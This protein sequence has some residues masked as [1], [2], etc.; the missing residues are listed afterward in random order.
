M[1]VLVAKKRGFCFGVENAMHLA[2]NLLNQKKH[3][4]CLG[5]LIH[6]RQAVARL[7]QAGLKV[8]DDIHEIPSFEADGSIPTVLI[9]SHGCGPAIIEELNKRGLTVVDA[10]CV[11]VK[12]LQKLA[13]QCAHEGF[14]VVVVGDKDH[15]EIQAVI[16]YVPD[17]IVIGG[18]DDLG[19]LPDAGRLAV[20]SQTT[21]SGDDFGKI[22]GLIAGKGYPEIRVLNT[23][24]RETARRQASAIELCH[25]VDVMFV[26]GGKHSANTG[27]L[28]DLCRRCG[29][30][31]YHL[32]G[33]SEFK[34]QYVAGKNVAGVTA[35]ASTPE[36]IIQ[37]FVEELQKIDGTSA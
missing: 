37:N 14:Q 18:E 5:E 12:K 32:Q 34:P 21:Y 8:V 33:W 24:C 31:T 29:V 11:L 7:T 4:Y 15:P 9:R 36:W 10:T 20:M 16:G 1:K 13:Q 30:E 35:G 22:V 3:V 28:A 2:E 25:A 27:E 26:L 6:N 23:I 19:Q 17:I